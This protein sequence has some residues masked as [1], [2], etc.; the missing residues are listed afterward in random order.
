MEL[1]HLQY[2]R[3]VAEELNF[4]HAAKRLFISQP[5]LSMTI[6]KLERELDTELFNR[7][8][9]TIT[10]TNQGQILLQS[11]EKI[12]NEL[13]LVKE[14]LSNPEQDVTISLASSHGRFIQMLLADFLINPSS[15][16]V[17]YGNLVEP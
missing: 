15:T 16:S 11:V 9:R 3:T 8:G 14:R 1:L 10:L 13:E 6:K 17:Q 7:N 2:F 5:A 12:E 4:T